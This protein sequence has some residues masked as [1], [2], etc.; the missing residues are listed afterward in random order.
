MALAYEMRKLGFDNP[1]TIAMAI[2]LY[3]PREKN[4]EIRSNGISYLADTIAGAFDLYDL[5]QSDEFTEDEIL[6]ATN[7]GTE[8]SHIEIATGRGYSYL[9]EVA[10]DDPNVRFETWHEFPPMSPDAADIT[11]WRV[12]PCGEVVA[13]LTLPLT[14]RAR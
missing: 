4:Y 13:R 14:A 2:I 3:Q 8:P 5:E 10:K 1:D 12:T 7:A 6:A 9:Y 11:L